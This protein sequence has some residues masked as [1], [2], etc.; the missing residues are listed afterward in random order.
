MYILVSV[1]FTFSPYNSYEE[2]VW[3][4]IAK[5]LDGKSIIM[6]GTTNRWFHRILMEETV[7][8]Y[9]C[10]RDL[11]VPDPQHAAIKWI[12]LYASAFGKY[13]TGMFIGY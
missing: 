5:Y 4:E 11:Q 3:T 1:S 12:K 6:L 13:Q 7:W 9:A 10:L 8:K 2:D